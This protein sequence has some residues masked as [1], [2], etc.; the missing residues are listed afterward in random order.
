MENLYV[1]GIGLGLGLGMGW[2]SFDRWAGFYDDI[3]GFR[4]VRI[5]FN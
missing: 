2:K 1:F 3:G 5:R 4:F